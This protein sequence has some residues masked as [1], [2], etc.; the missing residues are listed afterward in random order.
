MSGIITYKLGLK[1]RPTFSSNYLR[2]ALELGLI[3][4]IVPLFIME[5]SLNLIK[6]KEAL[7]V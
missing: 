7:P 4:M 3:E 2:T 5:S 1:H 6:G